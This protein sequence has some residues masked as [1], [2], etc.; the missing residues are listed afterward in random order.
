[1][2]EK[3]P[4]PGRRLSKRETLGQLARLME[5]AEQAEQQQEEAGQP[6]TVPYPLADPPAPVAPPR[7]PGLTAADVPVDNSGGPE[8][9]AEDAQPL[10]QELPAQRA[11]ESTHHGTFG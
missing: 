7:R 8:P 9:V 3:R 5:E 10:Q 4:K 1:M 11:G 2:R 6:E